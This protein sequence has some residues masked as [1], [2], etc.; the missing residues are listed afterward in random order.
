MNILIVCLGN[1][2]R[3]PMAEYIFKSKAEKKAINI[4]VESAGLTAAAGSQA[5]A[6][7]QALLLEDRIDCSSHRARQV[8]E[9]MIINA[10]LIL[11]MDTKQKHIIQHHFP[12][13]CGKTYLLGEWNHGEEVPDPINKPKIAFVNMKELVESSIDSWLVKLME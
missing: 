13:S 6:A 11:V 8:S 4:K 7:T 3:S 2:C 9:E 10:N 12:S 1:I 5:H